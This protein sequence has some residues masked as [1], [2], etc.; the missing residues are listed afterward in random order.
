M[1]QRDIASVKALTFDVFGT[2]VDWRG[3]IIREGSRRGAM[4]VRVADPHPNLLSQGE[5]GMRL[6]APAKGGGGSMSA[7]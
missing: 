6:L 1:A 5:G 4:N 2:V 3:S 7:S